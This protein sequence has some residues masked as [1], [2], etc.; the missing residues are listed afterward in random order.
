[1][2]TNGLVQDG[3]LSDAVVQGWCCY[4]VGQSG[5]IRI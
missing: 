1:V 5:C 4:C 3:H 2:R